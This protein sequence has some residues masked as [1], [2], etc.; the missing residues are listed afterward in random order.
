MRRES[1]PPNRTCEAELIEVRRIVVAQPLRQDLPLPSVRG[2]LKALQLPYNF[3]QSS[4]SAK[5]RAGGDMLP[6]RQ[7]AH[8][9]GG[10]GGFDLLAQHAEREAMDAGQQSPVAPFDDAIMPR[11]LAAQDGGLGFQ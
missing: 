6:A 5:L 1:A 11:E 3:P 2:D 4:L 7:P 9:L 10:S 8:E